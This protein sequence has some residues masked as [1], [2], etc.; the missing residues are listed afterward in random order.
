MRVTSKNSNKM[1]SQLNE[2]LKALQTKENLVMTFNA[3]V[4]E[5]VES[6]RPTYDYEKTQQHILELNKKIV[7]L[8]HAINQFNV[9]TKVEGYD[10]TIDEMLVYIPQL[11]QI[12]YKLDRMK[13]ILPK[14]RQE[15]YDRKT[16]IIDYVYANYDV[17]AINK[18]WLETK[19]KLADAQIAL[20]KTNVTVEIELEI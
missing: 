16:N 5:D 15:T 8:K 3:A 10:M 17:D 4:C 7:K 19:E 13:S 18:E 14:S 1:L 12:V 11:T 20:D 6:C 9:S 2:E